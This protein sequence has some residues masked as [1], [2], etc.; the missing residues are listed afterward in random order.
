MAKTGNRTS[1]SS[2]DGIAPALLG[3]YDRERRDLPWRRT[4][5]PYAV[6]VSEVMLQQTRV[7]TVVDYYTRFMHRFPSLQA[8]AEAAEDDVLKIW[9]GLGYYRRA[10]ALLAGARA[11]VAKHAG[12]LPA[13]P[14][15]LRELP[16]V[17]P[18]TA[19]AIASIAFGVREPVVDGNVTRV[20]CRLY[21]LAGDPERAP[22]PQ[23]IRRLASELVP[24]K[25]PGDFN[26][27]LMEL[28]ATLCTPRAPDCSAT[29]AARRKPRP[30]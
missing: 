30:R 17:G 16:G 24:A 27:A 13:E 28:G 14:A 10:R 12:R 19:G 29:A 20:L 1:I 3:W 5:D 4:R 8:L 25:R 18:Y 11:V 6:W 15:R 21:A 22:L 23:R 26:Q 9:Q 2:A 7:A